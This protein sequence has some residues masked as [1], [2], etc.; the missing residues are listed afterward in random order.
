M[1]F[2]ETWF[3]DSNTNIETDI[4]GFIC[5]RMDRTPESGKSLGGGVCIYVNQRWCTNICVK[6]HY[7]S[8][9]IKLI[10]VGLR[11]HYLP[12]EFPHIFV[13]VVY[14]HPRADVNNASTTIAEFVQDLEKQ[15]PD[16]VKLII[17]D[18]NECDL[19]HMMP[20]YHQ[21]VNIPTRGHRTLDKCYG[22]IPHAYKSFSRAPLGKSDH[23]ILPLYKQKLKQ[24]KPATR[25]VRSWNQYNMEALRSCFE[26]TDWDVLLDQDSIEDS[27]SVITDYVKFCED[28]IVP[29]K[30]IKIYPN[31]KPWLTKD[32]R[33]LV[34]RK[35]MAH[36]NNNLQG[37]RQLRKE[38]KH[39]VNQCKKQCGSKIEHK[40][41]NGDPKSA[42]NGLKNII[43]FGVRNKFKVPCSDL[44]QFVDDLSQFYSRFENRNT[45]HDPAYTQLCIDL[46][47]HTALK[48]IKMGLIE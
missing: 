41:E 26:C 22:N 11:P 7:F 4:D 37:K 43:G 20:H 18:F 28:L 25:K 12:R 44:K 16:A 47:V 2:S 32:L 35:Q 27:A 48:L 40:F 21:Y 38:I 13:T 19:K 36:I 1:C 29:E 39:L 14:I 8:P 10:T 3:K 45:C 23:D 30:V 17:G 6:Q 24:N 46:K 33:E 9:D 42:W 5:K 15:S 34:K 31:N